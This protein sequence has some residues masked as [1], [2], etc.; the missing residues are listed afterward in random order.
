MLSTN[1]RKHA[2]LS[3]PA[4][5]KHGWLSCF[6]VSKSFRMTVQWY[7]VCVVGS[8][9]MTVQSPI[10]DMMLGY[11]VLLSVY[12]SWY[13]HTISCGH[14][15]IMTSIAYR[16]NT[17]CFCPTLTIVLQY[18]VLALT[19]IYIFCLESIMFKHR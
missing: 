3:C 12:C 16:T 2:W 9:R 10:I 7:V 6:A 18:I 1:I 8:F 13:E 5:R 11:H 19:S 14:H 4:V 17:V 15:D